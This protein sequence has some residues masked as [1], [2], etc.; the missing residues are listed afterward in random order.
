M[1]VIQYYVRLIWVT[2]LDFRDVDKEC[3][4]IEDN[5]STTV[6]LVWKQVSKKFKIRYPKLCVKN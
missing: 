4:R 6:D 2:K 5:Y 1:K 3:V